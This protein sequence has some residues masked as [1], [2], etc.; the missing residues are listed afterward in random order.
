MRGGEKVKPA[1]V[2]KETRSAPRTAQQLA[3]TSS[4][5]QRGRHMEDGSAA[6][7]VGRHGAACARWLQLHITS[8]KA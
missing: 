7:A 4:A 8:K 2:L 6:D 1:E 5:G 3:R